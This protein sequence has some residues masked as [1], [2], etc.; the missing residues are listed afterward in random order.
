MA[1]WATCKIG[2]PIQPIWQ[3]FF[4]LPWS[5]L[6]KPSWELKLLHIFAVPMS[7]RHEKCFQ[8]LKILFVV[9]HHSSNI[10][11]SMRLTISPCKWKEKYLIMRYIF[12]W[13]Q[14]NMYIVHTYLFDL[15]NRKMPAKRALP[16]RWRVYITGEVCI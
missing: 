7:S 1:F 13:F 3:K 5:A 4:A 6:K 8:I 14:N 16:R 12:V 9:F 15:I 2:Q 11:W 10:L